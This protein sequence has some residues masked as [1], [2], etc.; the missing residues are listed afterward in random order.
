MANVLIQ[1]V[2]KYYDKK[3]EPKKFGFLKRDSNAVEPRPAVDQVDIHIEDGSFTVIVGPSG[4]GKSTM[5]R[6][7]A[8]LEEV[9]KGEIKISDRVVNDLPPG[10]RNI[11]MVFQNYALYPMMNVYQNIA[12]GLENI[13]VLGYTKYVERMIARKLGIEKENR[14][15]M[16]RLDAEWRKAV[17]SKPEE[18]KQKVTISNRALRWQT[19]EKM[20]EWVKGL[21]FDVLET[22][23]VAQKVYLLEDEGTVLGWV[24]EGDV[25]GV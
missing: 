24:M 15:I 3:E 12:F 23:E 9:D 2:S 11:S 13:K 14:G 6:M 17:A 25:V 22:K 8:G 10:E 1:A 16:D 20:A 18:V 7:I 4:C 5:L 19:G 21:S